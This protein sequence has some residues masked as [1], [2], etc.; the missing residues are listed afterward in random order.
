MKEL[1]KPLFWKSFDVYYWAGSLSGSMIF[2]WALFEHAF[3]L[4]HKLGITMKNAVTSL[5]YRKV[6]STN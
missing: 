5:M 1:S 3:L 6:G 2:S 4:A